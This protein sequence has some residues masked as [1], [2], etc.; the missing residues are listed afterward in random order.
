ML[1]GKQQKQ[2]LVTHGLPEESHVGFR[3]KK[4]GYQGLPVTELSSDQREQLQKVMSM[5]IEPYR[6]S[7]RDEVTKCLKSQGGLE[8]AHLA[9]YAD[10]RHRRRRRVGHLAAGRAVVR[11]ALPRRAARARVGQRGGRSEREAE[12]I[13]W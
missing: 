13:A 12:R 11:V 9:Y 1:D 6:Q 3:G 10:G 2:A 4:G 8:H 5:L 7:D